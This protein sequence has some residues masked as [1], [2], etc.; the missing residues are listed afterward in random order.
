MAESASGVDQS[1]DTVGLDGATGE[2]ASP[3]SR[4][5]GSLLGLEELLLG[6]GGLGTVVGVTE[7]RAENGEGDGVAVSGTNGDSR[8]LNGGEVCE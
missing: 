2:G 6:V 4:G 3:C 5:G 1:T 7:E 8:R